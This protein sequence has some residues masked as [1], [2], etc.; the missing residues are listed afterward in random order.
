MN[1]ALVLFENKVMTAA[2]KERVVKH[3]AAALVPDE[4]CIL[5]HIPAVFGVESALGGGFS[6]AGDEVALE[7]KVSH[8]ARGIT[9]AACAIEST[10]L[11][12]AVSRNEERTNRKTSL[13]GLFQ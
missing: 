3:I 11:N 7:K 12:N 4:G 8:R 2:S 5:H 6:A 1:R 10:I 9:Y 13:I